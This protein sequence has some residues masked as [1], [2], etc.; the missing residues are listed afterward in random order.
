MKYKDIK[1]LEE[2]LNR[3]KEFSADVANAQDIINRG[4]K[5]LLDLKKDALELRKDIATTKAVLEKELPANQDLSD[6]IK[7]FDSIIKI[8]DTFD[9]VEEKYEQYFKERR[10][11]ND[12]KRKS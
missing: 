5:K 11:R 2:L 3:S 4:Y 10:K 9:E 7:S 6:I 8:L 1:G 12:K